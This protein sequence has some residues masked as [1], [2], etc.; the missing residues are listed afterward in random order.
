MV[1]EKKAVF[2]IAQRNFR[3]EEFFIPKEI[4][5]KN[6]IKVVV[7]SSSLATASGMLGA[8]VKPDILLKDIK[9]ADFDAIVFIGGS[10]S[11]QYWGDSLAHS[12]AQEAV[13]QNKVLA[14]ICIAP[15]TLANAGVLAGKKCTVWPSES[16]VLRAK[17]GTATG[18]ELEV[19][20]LIVTASGPE[21]AQKFGQALLEELK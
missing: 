12:L 11:S 10:G 20:G 13:K 17:G 1:G 14:A 2:I 3:D 9:A 8:K 4:L 5:E 21:A 18:T 6:Q 19:D 7:G 15:V 16:A